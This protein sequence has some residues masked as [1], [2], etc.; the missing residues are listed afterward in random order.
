MC[1]HQK[2]ITD[3]LVYQGKFLCK[4]SLKYPF[5]KKS[6][7]SSANRLKNRGD[8]NVK[9]G[10]VLTPI[11]SFTSPNLKGK[12]HLLPGRV[13]DDRR[14]D[15]VF[16]PAQTLIDNLQVLSFDPFV[17]GALSLSLPFLVH[18]FSFSLPYVS[19][20]RQPT[21]LEGKIWDNYHFLDAVLPSLFHNWNWWDLSFSPLLSIF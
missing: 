9:K 16:P 3:F 8:T 20:A 5:G 11:L 14:T 6:E 4:V 15:V 7:C 17:A 21:E 19:T 2:R 10:L 13:E 1:G 12:Y 18:P